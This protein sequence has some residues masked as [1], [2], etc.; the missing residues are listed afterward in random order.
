LAL[1]LLV[2]VSIGSFVPLKK[3][4]AMP[5]K[6]VGTAAKSPRRSLKTSLQKKGKAGSSTQMMAV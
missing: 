4:R 6:K 3:F 2:E 5:D 1:L